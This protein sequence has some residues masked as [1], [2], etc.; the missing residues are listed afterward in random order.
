MEYMQNLVNAVR[1]PVGLANRITDF[2][3]DFAK[4]KKKREKGWRTIKSKKNWNKTRAKKE[5][6]GL[7]NNFQNHS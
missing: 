6:V 7:T 2:F 3:L 4:K 1:S 5:N